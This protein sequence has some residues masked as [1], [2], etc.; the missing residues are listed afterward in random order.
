VPDTQYSFE[1]EIG[2]SRR[3]FVSMGGPNF[4]N[5]PAVIFDTPGNVLMAPLAASALI[6]IRDAWLSLPGNDGLYNFGAHV[7]VSPLLR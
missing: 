5:A 1:S 2:S 7:A 6:S 4:T 3:S